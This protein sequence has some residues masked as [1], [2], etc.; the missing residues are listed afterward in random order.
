MNWD[1]R[2]KEQASRRFKNYKILAIDLS[3]ARTNEEHPLPGDC[4]Y[5]L[6][7]TDVTTLATVRLNAVTHEEI[8][9]SKNRKIKTV[10]TTFF[11]SNTAQ[12]G[13]TMTLIAGIDF[14]VDDLTAAPI[15]IAIEE[16][17][18]AI[19][20]TNAVANTNTVGASH[21]A[22]K[23]IIIALT[24]NTGLV[25]VNLGAAAVA[26][27]CYPLAAGDS[28]TVPLTNTNKINALFVVANEKVTVVYANTV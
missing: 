10:F 9:L 4:L 20:I 17:Q 25:W 5:V 14:D 23:A 8:S 15:A 13:K 27:S 16:A 28:I 7:V 24:T 12:T 2:L 18:P 26:G 21:A 19:Q 6:E 11:I 3:I 22:T 1:A